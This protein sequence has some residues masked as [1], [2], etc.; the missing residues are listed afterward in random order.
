MVKVRKRSL[1][2]LRIIVLVVSAAALMMNITY[3]L[4]TMEEETNEF[5]HEYVRPTPPTQPPG[6]TIDVEVTKAWVSPGGHPDYVEV[7]LYRTRNGSTSGYGS[8]VR[9][10]DGNEWRHTW[11]GLPENCIW[12]VE[13]VH[14]PDGYKA[15]I[16]G[17]AGNGFVITNTKDE[18]PPETPP[19]VTTPPPP[20]PPPPTTP[21]PQ[22]P[23]GSNGNGNGTDIG[24]QD[25]P[26][27][28]VDNPDDSNPP[29]GIPKTGDETDPGLWLIIL[30]VT[31]IALRYVLFFRKSKNKKEK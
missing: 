27:S 9:L 29:S 20:T 8:P 30:T 13:E 18:P 15:S 24:D 17:S 22:P 25:I 11:T 23:P 4:G 2:L 14:V 31:A 7:Q 3:G 12:T 26:G 28:G 10:D 21:P 16:S 5:E 6:R 1:R 19:P